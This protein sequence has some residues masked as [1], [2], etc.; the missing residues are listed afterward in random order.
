MEFHENHQN[1]PK[2]HENHQNTW[3]FTKITKTHQNS[4]K[5]PKH[6]EFHE[7]HP[8]T[9]KP[10]ITMTSRETPNRIDSL[11]SELH[12]RQ[13][14]QTSHPTTRPRHTTCSILRT[15]L[16]F[17]P[18]TT[19]TSPMQLQQQMFKQSPHEPRSK[20]THGEALTRSNGTVP[21]PK[22]QC[23]MTGLNKPKSDKSP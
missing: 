16:V 9:R 6:M 17:S 11:P 7:N 12:P 1:S 2:T 18:M 19:R 22:P 5:P 3:N 20:L 8:N 15:H 4:R 10:W 21:L 23:H 13:L 14:Y